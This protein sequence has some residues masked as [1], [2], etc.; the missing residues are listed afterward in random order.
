MARRGGGTSGQGQA[1]PAVP[2][3]EI[4][5]EAPTAPA[6]DGL[7]LAPGQL[8]PLPEP[9]APPPSLFEPPA[10]EL[11]RMLQRVQSLID[12]RVHY[13]ACVVRPGP[14]DVCHPERHPS[15][16]QMPVAASSLCQGGR[17]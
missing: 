10:V 5:P 8:A 2:R 12:G 15:D 6:T 9:M 4:A 14:A 13:L 3:E 16:P 1:A 11:R 7:N 17:R